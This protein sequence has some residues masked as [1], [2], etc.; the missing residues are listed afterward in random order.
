MQHLSIILHATYLKIMKMFSLGTPLFISVEGKM[1]HNK[2]II[3][4]LLFIFMTQYY[5]KSASTM[6]VFYK[7]T[8]IT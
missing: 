6:Y 7:L 8:S 1:F 3:K 4:Y 2:K 5:K